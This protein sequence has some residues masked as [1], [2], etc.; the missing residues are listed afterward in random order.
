[1]CEYV[2]IYNEVGVEE[3]D[4]YELTKRKTSRKN[5]VEIVHV[6][7]GVKRFIHKDRIL[8]DEK[9]REKVDKKKEK[10]VEENN[11]EKPVKAKKKKKKPLE[12]FDVS[13]LDGSIFKLKEKK[14]MDAGEQKFVVE[15][16]CLVSDDATKMKYFQL[17]NGSL[18]KKSRTP[19]LGDGDNIDR[20]E[21][22]GDPKAI[23]EYLNKKGYLKI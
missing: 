9:R 6:R 18:G 11:T 20:A 14:E 21:I 10:K 16:Y 19:T 7:T 3:L 1:M 5:I 2:R 4:L 12:K 8:E 22:C 17:Y 15:S 23:T 13:T